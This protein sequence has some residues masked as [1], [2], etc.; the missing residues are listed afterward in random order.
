[1]WMFKKVF[2]GEESDMVKDT[3]HPLKDLNYRELIVMSPLIVL[4]FW[5]GLFPNL[6]LDPT[7]KSLNHLLENRFNYNLT[8]TETTQSEL[9]TAGIEK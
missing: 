8:V 1:L 4:V 3:H 2:F 5:M 7:N 6:F 9:K